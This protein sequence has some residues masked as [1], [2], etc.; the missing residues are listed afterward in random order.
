[1]MI[2]KQKGYS[3]NDIIEITGLS[4]DEIE[5]LE[6][7]TK[8]RH[9]NRRWTSMNAEK[10]ECYSKKPDHLFGLPLICPSF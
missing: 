3:V 2:L 5:T 1:M 9:L 7:Y 10:I 6:I 8:K 4:R